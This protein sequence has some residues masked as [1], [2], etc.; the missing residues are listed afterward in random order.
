MEAIA[1]LLPILLLASITKADVPRCDK[2]NPDFSASP[3]C[4][5]SDYNLDIIPPTDGPLN[6]NVDVFVFEVKL[7][8]LLC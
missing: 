5:P 2:N 8:I 1:V 6:V 3:Y 4:L 7:K